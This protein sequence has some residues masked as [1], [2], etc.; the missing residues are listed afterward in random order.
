[1]M[2]DRLNSLDNGGARFPSLRFLTFT[3]F[4][5]ISVLEFRKTAKIARYFCRRPLDAMHLMH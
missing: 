1:M 2:D 5:R 4:G 3:P